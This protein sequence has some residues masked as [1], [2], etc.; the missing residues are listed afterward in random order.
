MLGTEGCL[1][2]GKIYGGDSKAWVLIRDWMTG[3]WEINEPYRVGL[4]NSIIVGWQE[5][6]L[7][8]SQVL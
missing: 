3:E 7:M 2:V 5:S 4:W 1:Q 8:K 6:S